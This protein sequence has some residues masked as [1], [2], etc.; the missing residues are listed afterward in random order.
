MNEKK[1]NMGT[2]DVKKDDMVL[3][4]KRELVNFIAWSADNLLGKHH[5][6]VIN[7][8]NY[9]LNPVGEVKKNGNE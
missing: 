7:F 6:E 2:K 8:I 9:L 5:V 3:V 4:S 1:E